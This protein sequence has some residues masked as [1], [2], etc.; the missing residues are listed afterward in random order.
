MYDV[1]VTPLAQAAPARPLPG[2]PATARPALAELL[3]RPAQAH[4]TYAMSRVDASGR[5][6]DK[7]LVSVLGWKVDDRL[8]TTAEGTSVIILGRDSCG[9]D[10]LITKDRVRLP[11]SLRTRCG[12]R[13][14]DRVLLAASP[15]LDLLLAYPLSTLERALGTLHQANAEADR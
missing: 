13:I 5:I 12:I 9:P 14:G 15:K 2:Q 4:W 3:A 8:I 7:Q 10:S 1:F 6:A 11:V